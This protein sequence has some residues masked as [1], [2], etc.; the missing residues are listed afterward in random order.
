MP[1][2]AAPEGG[3]G[4]RERKKAATRAAIA[5]AAL[6]LFLERGY[7]EVSI[8]DIAAE[9]D[10]AVA[11]VFSHFAGKEELVFD[12]ND[13]IRA[14]L[15]S[16]VRDRTPGRPVLDALEEWATT[17]QALRVTSG[18]AY[19]DFVGLIERTPELT[20]AWRRLWYEHGEHLADALVEASADQP[21]RLSPAE[22]LSLARTVLDA[23]EIARSS[24]DPDKTVHTLFA[25]VRG[26]W[27]H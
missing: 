23:R 15:L 20:A 6:T 21:W 25:M 11:T 12:K 3:P 26:G 9:A 13:E 4:R 5:S 24:D 7:R 10:V 18:Q 2:T 19:Y 1:D 14:Q 8:K 16:A 17:T 27:P 22:A